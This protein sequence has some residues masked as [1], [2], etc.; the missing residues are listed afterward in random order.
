MEFL[1]LF[2]KGHFP[3]KKSRKT[4]NKSFIRLLTGINPIG[5][6]VDRLGQ[7]VDR[8]LEL[9]HAHITPDTAGGSRAI[10]FN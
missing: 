1:E 10:H 2:L 7:V 6:D 4:E 9:F 8:R 5:I 3:S